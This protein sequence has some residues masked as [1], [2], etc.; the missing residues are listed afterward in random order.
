MQD[1]VF[2]IAVTLI[3][4]AFVLRDMLL[5]RLRKYREIT[6][7]RVSRHAIQREAHSL[8]SVFAMPAQRPKAALLICH[9]IGEVVESWRSA[10]ELLAQHC[11]ASLVFDY[12]GFGKS[13]GTV[14]WR[15]CEEDAVS[16]FT[17]LKTMVPGV[18]I[19]LLG[20]S[21]GS[22]IACAINQRVSPGRLI[23]CSA[24]T[25][26]RDAACAL[27]LPRSLEG[28]LP[29]I[30]CARESI[31]GCAVPILV[32]HCARD[33]AFPVPMARQ[34]ACL[35]GGNAELVIVPE[36]VHNEAFY[37]PKL[38]YWSHVIGWMIET[39]SPVLPEHTTRAHKGSRTQQC[40]LLRSGE[41]DYS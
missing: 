33:R 1:L 31:A 9:G 24:F 6:D 25:S 10:Q 30:W 32:V 40:D 14:N 11:V 36:Q 35:F 28:L 26:F 7:V 13:S 38:S 18:P 22:G 15:S 12:S 29:P 39:T 3:C 16:A 4:R 19:S 8:D 37:D 17:F 21:M 2:T 20:F 34:L 5:G 23:L 27:G 41:A